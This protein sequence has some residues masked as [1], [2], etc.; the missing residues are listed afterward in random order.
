MKNILLMF[1]ISLIIALSGCMFQSARY[2]PDEIKSF[3]QYEQIIRQN[4]PKRQIKSVGTLQFDIDCAGALPVFEDDER[5]Y[6]QDLYFR[7]VGEKS[8]YVY[9]AGRQRLYV[10][11]GFSYE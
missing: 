3:S 9:K 2:S 4:R 5:V 7:M 8:G 1:C 6:V 10:G 11:F